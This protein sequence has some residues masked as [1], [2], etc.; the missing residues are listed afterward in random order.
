MRI[1]VRLARVQGASR[2]ID[3]TQA[4]IDGCIF[5]GDA[6]LRFA[7]LFADD[8]GHVAVPTTT[9]IISVDRD[10][11]AAQGVSEEWAHKATK[12][13]DAYLRMGARPTF[14]CSPYQGPN[15]P[16][17]GEQIAWAESNAIAFANGALG[18]R[19]NR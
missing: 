1:L 14:T 13:G 15:P 5:T 18:A 11:W 16:A 6:L 2:F 3:I 7:E 4:H 8:G 17:F 10:R 19:T 12:L 9:N